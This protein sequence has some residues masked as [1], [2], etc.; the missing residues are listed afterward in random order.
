MLSEDE[1]VEACIA[2]TATEID[3][4]E[5]DDGAVCEGRGHARGEVGIAAVNILHPSLVLCQISDSQSYH[6]VL[7]KM[8]IFN[9]VEIIVPNTFCDGMQPSKLFVVL[10]DFYQCVTPVQRRHFND[11][12]GLQHIQRICVSEYASV[13]M[14]ITPKFYALSAAAALL[15]YIEYS[16]NKIFVAKSLKVEYQG[17]LNTTIIDAAVGDCKSRWC[18]D[19]GT[20]RRLE[21]VRSQ[22]GKEARHSLLG[23]LDRCCT[24]GGSRAL[25]ASLLQP[26]CLHETLQQRLDC[27]QELVDCPELLRAL[28]VVMPRFADVEKLLG[29]SLHSPQQESARASETQL[30]YVMLLKTSLELLPALRTTLEPARCR[31]LVSVKQVVMCM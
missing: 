30:K 2:N 26:P 5:D 21:L 7:T 13:E 11:T 17:S 9:P 23:V 6:N 14:L 10:S 16:R 22:R 12:A 1:I 29:L 25:R 18:A 19:V 31:L 28:Q 27:V 15:R 4:S 24:G 3:S 20:A 8:N